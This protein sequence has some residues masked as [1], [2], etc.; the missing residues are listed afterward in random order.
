[1]IRAI[2][3]IETGSG[4]TPTSFRI[5]SCPADPSCEGIVF[6]APHDVRRCRAGE[7]VVVKFCPDDQFAHE[8]KEALQS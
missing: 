4:T 1:M 5:L 2:A 6:T 3:I 8:C 7:Y